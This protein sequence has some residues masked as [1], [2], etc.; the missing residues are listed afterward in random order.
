MNYQLGRE[1][2]NTK[3]V[4]YLLILLALIYNIMLMFSD[5]SVVYE[6]SEKITLNIKTNLIESK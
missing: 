6:D 5:S 2:M 1:L 3:K 4:F